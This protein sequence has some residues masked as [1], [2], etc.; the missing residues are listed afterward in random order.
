MSKDWFSLSRES[1][2]IWLLSIALIFALCTY[3]FFY[4]YQSEKERKVEEVLISQKI[5]AKQAARS[6]NVLIN[7][8]NSLLH[9]L[10]RDRNIILM[11]KE[12]EVELEGLLRILKDEIAAITRTDEKG[13]IIFSIPYHPNAIGTDISSQKHMIK[14]LKDHKPVISD[15][16]KVIQG[17]NAVVI[18]YPITVNKKYK[19]SIA[20]LIDFEKIAGE[21]LDKLSKA[22]N[23]KTWLLSEAGV[24]M[25]CFNKD[26]IG[27]SAF[28]TDGKRTEEVRLANLMLSVKEG[29][30][31]FT[32]E[33]DKYGKTNAI[34]YFTHIKVNDSFWSLAAASSLE[35]LSEPL[36][37]FSIQLGL[38]FFILFAGGILLSN[39]VLKA[40][41][42]FK[43]TEARKKAEEELKL[44][45]EKHR[46]ISEVSSDYIF[47][48]KVDGNSN[49]IHDWYSG[50]FTSMTEYTFEEYQ[51][52]GGWKACVLPEDNYIDDIALNRLKNNLTS[53]AELR[54]VTKSG[55]IMWVRVFA[56]PVWDEKENK[57]VGIYGAVQDIN[58]NKKAEFDLIENEKKFRTIY[59]SINEAMFIHDFQTGALV[60]VNLTMEKMFGVTREEA[61]NSSVND[62][63]AGFAPYTQIEAMEWM[64]KTKEY[65]PQT[66]EWL[67]KT[68]TGNIFWAEVSMS[69]VKI[70]GVQRLLAAVRDITER[71][72]Y[73]YQLETFRLAMDQSPASIVI[74]DS[75]G[76]IEYVNAGFCKITGFEN[77]ELIGVP[78]RILNDNKE[79]DINREEIWNRIKEGKEWRSEHR[80]KRKDGTF[81]WES[82]II[83]PVIDSDGKIIHLLAVQEDISVR[84][85][86]E[87][88]LKDT[89]AKAKELSRLKS[90]FLT[91]MSHDLRTPLVGILGCSE[92]LC[93]E[94]EGENKEL[95][96]MINTSSNRLHQTLKTI[97][98]YSK[99]E[100][101]EIVPNKSKVSVLEIVSEEVKL[102]TPLAVKNELFIKQEFLCNKFIAESDPVLLKEVIDN[103]ISN[104][105]RYTL[106]GEITVTVEKNNSEFRISVA[107]TGIGIPEEK[108]DIIFEEFRQVSEG[109]G[110]NFDGTGLG[111]T[112]AKKYVNALN[113]TIS[114]KSKVGVGSTFTICL[115]AG[116]FSQDAKPVETIYEKIQI[117]PLANSEKSVVLLVEDDEINS[118]TITK[119]I[120]EFCIVTCVNNAISALN[121]VINK[122]Y[123]FILMD[124]N[125]KLGMSGLE[126]T[127]EI[128]RIPK[129]AETPI[130]ALTAYALNN[131]EEEFLQSGFSHYL[132]KPFSKE[133]IT[134]LILSINKQIGKG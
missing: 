78:L 14:I 127:K 128:R 71:K 25:Y 26:H 37:K 2:R 6:F 41:A 98:S 109:K 89:I 99:I 40:A 63:S 12:G 74:T 11:N 129:Y 79:M 73:E 86:T 116:A 56:H 126:A 87:Q 93:D 65:G 107:D 133:Q 39:Y 111:L 100:S 112:I 52:I 106:E 57:L 47:A 21:I 8:W 7:K 125:L 34:V 76:K 97:L 10:S 115:P 70:S 75:E 45:E 23:I 96:V 92:L 108:L 82:T 80:N 55:K 122:K 49:L 61:I 43:E 95:A 46:L 88:Q 16:F 103:L 35:Q 119:M 72:K 91:N 85:E 20:L 101:E 105:I 90:N 5:H 51:K 117:E 110:R 53:T 132:S 18:H 121:F 54:T 102:F 120:E 134:G 1:N 27:K 104:A 4:F 31:M 68:K 114:V 64:R 22:N 50:A 48:T 28:E 66:F 94:L 3:L 81:Y 59:N 44:S 9:Q 30:E 19:G 113:G 131:D 130:V 69:V 17:Y 32:F 83:S 38:V 36:N 42:V 84:K 67:A 29:Q 13:K 62:I 118:L 15:V 33:D 77:R 123:D 124:V 58:E 24:E 60:D